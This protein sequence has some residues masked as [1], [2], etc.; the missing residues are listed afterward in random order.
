MLNERKPVVAVYEHLPLFSK[1]VTAGLKIMWHFVANGMKWGCAESLSG[2]VY[3]CMC[4]CD[5]F[6]V[7][8][9]IKQG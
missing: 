3:K 1:A 4:A 9:N 7:V 5:D 8:L 6:S 2:D